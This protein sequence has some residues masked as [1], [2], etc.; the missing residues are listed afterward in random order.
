MGQLTPP[1][2]RQLQNYGQFIRSKYGSFLNATYDKSRVYARSTDYDRTLQSAYSFLTGL[3]RPNSDQQWT[4]VNTQSD[5]LPIPV[6]TNALAT[7]SVT[8]YF[9]WEFNST[10]IWFNL[11][12]SR[13]Y[14]RMHR[15]RDTNSWEIFPATRLSIWNLKLMLKCA[16]NYIWS[17]WKSIL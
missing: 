14:M 16:F 6:H 11:I 8:A 17:I 4:N 7:D 12:W 13:F 5:Y 9:H 3:F 2:M 1:G 10:G 15:V